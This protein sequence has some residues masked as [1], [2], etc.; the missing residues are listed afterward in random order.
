V[1]IVDENTLSTQQTEQAEEKF[2]SSI[3]TTFNIHEQLAFSLLMSE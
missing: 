3:Y 2:I 1:D